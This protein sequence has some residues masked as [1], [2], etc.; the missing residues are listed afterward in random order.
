MPRDLHLAA[1]F[2]TRQ[3]FVPAANGEML[4]VFI[5]SLKGRN[6]KPGG[7]HALFFCYA[8]RLWASV[9]ILNIVAC[10]HGC[11]YCLT[12]G[13]RRVGP[14]DVHEMKDVQDVFVSLE[15][16]PHVGCQCSDGGCLLMTS[17]GQG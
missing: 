9:L 4:P 2:E 8:G 12:S 7:Y 15:V 14:E 13:G 17:Y 5:T 16:R 11:Q 1:R 10:L 3:E 6:P